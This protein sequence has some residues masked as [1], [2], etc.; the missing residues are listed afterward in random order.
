MFLILALAG[1]A[2]TWLGAQPAPAQAFD[3]LIRNGRVLDGTGTPWYRADIGIRGDRIVAVGALTASKARSVVDAQDRFV[4]PG[5]VDVHSHAGPGLLTAGLKHG[6]PVLAQGITT[7]LV[8]P[9]GGGPVDL[10]GQRATYTKQGIG[11]NVGLFVP[12]GSIRQ[13]VMA[14]SDR[15]PDPGEL[16]RMVALTREGMQ[17][18]GVGLS[19]GLYYAPGSYSKT[20]EVVAM[21]KATAPFGGVYSSHIR[22]EA[23]YTIGV[24]A[25]VDEVITIAEQGG[26]VGV[27]SH[28]KALG[29]ASWGLSKT[30]VE[31]IEAAR[32]RGVQVFADQYAYEASGT[33]IVGALMPRSAQ[34]G[35]RDAMMKRIRGELRDEIRANVRTNIARRGGAETLMISRYQPD[36]SLEGQ[37]LSDLAGK[38]GVPPEEYAL[39]L[40]EKG[41][42][43]LV[44]F[45]MSEDDIERIMRQPWTMTCTDGDLV[46]LGQGKPHPRAYGAFARKLKRYV[47]ER[48]TLDL[49]AAIR[50][51]TSMPA[52]IF[53]LKDRGQIRSGAFADLLIFDLAQVNDA[54]TY[55]DPHQLAEGFTDILVN[56]QWARRENRFSTTLAGRVLAPE[57]R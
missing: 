8:N 12:H 31:H 26:V 1:V 5:F 35:G 16:S 11:P 10:A 52:T 56:G 42:A 49:A 55:E 38:A 20:A 3:I 41:D 7:V 50:T 2:T 29:P 57:R 37:R 47:R 9:D 22:D 45:N 43:S 4:S 30:L 40:L 24:V 48:G 15:D 28:M 13:Q 36:P 25:A 46:P 14:M 19:S 23:D 32:T 27:V 44:S 54:A 17:A 33:G 34:V 6:Q 18:G 53:G 21:A 51:M 39:L